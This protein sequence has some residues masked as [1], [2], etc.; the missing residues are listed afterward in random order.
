MRQKKINE[1]DGEKK[2]SR[3]GTRI[4]DNHKEQGR[5]SF[6]PNVGDYAVFCAELWKT[7]DAEQK[8]RFNGAALDLNKALL[9]EYVDALKP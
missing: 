9:K 6:G 7:F 3:S 5:Y 2:K 1:D 8:G 4:K